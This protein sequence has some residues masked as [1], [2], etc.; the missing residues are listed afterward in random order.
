[1]FQ[2]G[3]RLAFDKNWPKWKEG[4][5]FKALREKTK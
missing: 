5:E 2:T 3:K 4:S 1:L